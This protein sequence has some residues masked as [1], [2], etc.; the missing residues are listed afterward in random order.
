MQR[1]SQ[2]ESPREPQPGGARSCGLRWLAGLALVLLLAGTWGPAI[3]GA[4]YTFD[5]NEGVLANPA[6]NGAHSPLS[7]FGRDYWEHHGGA[8]HY[9]PLAQL[10]LALD[11]R[12]ATALQAPS[13]AAHDDPPPAWVFRTSGLALHVLVVLFAALLGRQLTRGAGRVYLPFLLA[14][15]AVH[16]LQADVAAWISARSSTL[17]L[18]PG[19]ALAW[20]ALRRPSSARRA[21]LCAGLA[22]LLGLLAKED[23]YLS[24][25]LVLAALAARRSSTAV[26]CEAGHGAEGQGLLG[27]AQGGAEQKDVAPVSAPHPAGLHAGAPHESPAPKRPEGRAGGRSPAAQHVQLAAL[28]GAGL[29]LALALGMR[30]L[31]LGTWLPAAPHAPLAGEPLGERL[32]M[33]LAALGNG[34]LGI[35]NPA[36]TVPIHRAE[37]L[38]VEPFT[39]VAAGLAILLVAGLAWHHRRTAAG[40]WFALVLAAWLPFTQLVPAGEVLA[41]RFFYA[42]L[43]CFTLGLAAAERRPHAAT[44]TLGLLLLVV[45]CY[46]PLARQ[47]AAMYTDRASFARSVIARHPADARAWND[48]GVAH[49]EAGERLLARRALERAVRLDA[50]YG[51]P[52]SN[53]GSLALEDGDLAR[54]EAHFEAAARLGPGNPVA[55]ANLGAFRLRQDEHAA[56]RAAYARA[57]ELAP[58]LAAAWRGLGRALLALDETAAGAAA[59][60]R[61]LA[62][63]PTDVRA[64]ELLEGLED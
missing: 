16:P 3:A 46:V 4:G 37:H 48:L 40:W 7:A 2:D 60:E 24:G 1:G 21:F 61:A 53:L 64:R 62:H 59:L 58:G 42:P 52:H 45:A 50:T 35:F 13:S 54:A 32:L 56:A 38:G 12:I 43:L 28:L 29:G 10:S 11:H 34:V 19:L 8:G 49:L 44:R 26:P 31:A 20:V 51:R 18:L 25:L 36:F 17:A 55:F 14:V 27:S 5:D 9:R 39:L 41:P 63:D 33:G 30:G 47:D 22:T 6:I 57:V 23:G 15:F